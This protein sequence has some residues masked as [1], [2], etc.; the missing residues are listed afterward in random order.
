MVANILEAV[1]RIKAD[2]AAHLSAETIERLCRECGYQWR[3]R[4]LGP[5]RTVH[6]FLL[7]ILQGNTACDHLPRL[8]GGWFT[9]EAYCLARARLPLELFDRLLRAVCDSLRACRDEGARWCG[10]RLWFVDGSG[11]SMPDTPELQAAF[12]QPGG[13]KPGCGF[14]VA[15]LLM[16][17]HAGTGLLQK[18][19]VSPLRT[20]DLADV[21]EL[22]RHL[23]P[24]DVLVGDRG[25]C[26]FAHL[27]LL[28][29]AGLHGIFRVHQKQIVSFRKG[30]MHVPPSPPF[31]K[32][33]GARGLPRSRWVKWLG[34][35]D[36]IVEYFKPNRRPTWMSV[37]DYA[38]LPEKITVRE[39]R[40]QVAQ[41]GFR[42]HQVTLVTTLVDPVCY[43][44]G[45]LAQ[46]YCDRWR[47]EVNIRHLKQTLRMDVLH[48]KT[49]AGV[50]KELRM[51]AIAYNLV[52]LVMIAA[53]GRQKVP[54]DR[55]SFIDA[56]RW[57][58]HAGSAES[59]RVLDTLVVL[60]LRP[61]R[62]EP[63]VRKRRPKE[64]PLMK[65]P[66]AQL[67]KALF[68][69]GSKA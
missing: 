53:A 42:V 47:V 21:R 58:C 5:V 64:Y 12:G 55:I 27:A 65:Q 54:V 4:R 23:A 39:L 29:Q 18:I 9:G 50:N 34:R 66:R 38:A 49:V 45:E 68:P 67:R 63:R 20:H 59:V 28:L 41:P 52:R 31:P 15:H 62:A 19:V 51:F 57:L 17:F 40:Y 61:G 22:H 35:C 2:V 48:T 30:R 36:Q 46:A 7:Q 24:Q 10:H 60:P 33:K 69:M 14:P 25:L 37:E 16:L 56:L 8:V 6:L 26:S 11:C 32:L 43:P 13:Q 44:A 3:E 1:R